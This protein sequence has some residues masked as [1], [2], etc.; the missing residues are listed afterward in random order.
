[1]LTA[2]DEVVRAGDPPEAALTGAGFADAAFFG[3][4]GF[5]FA[6]GFF[7]APALDAVLDALFAVALPAFFAT[8]FAAFFAT[9]FFGFDF[10]MALLGTLSSGVNERR[11]TTSIDLWSEEVWDGPSQRGRH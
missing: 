1:M 4:A 3:A 11:E 10:A 9:T 7:A 8:V 5:T 2:V 6:A